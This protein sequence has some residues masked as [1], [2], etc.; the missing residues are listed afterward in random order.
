M[1]SYASSLGCGNVILMCNCLVSLLNLS[2]IFDM[3]MRVSSILSVLFSSFGLGIHGHS[4]L[5]LN[6]NYNYKHEWNDSTLQ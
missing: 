1:F 3:K 5:D 2:I 4:P 6:K